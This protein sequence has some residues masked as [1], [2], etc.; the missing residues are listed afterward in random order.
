MIW[1]QR[2]AP[3]G[4]PGDVAYA[5]LLGVAGAAGGRL[6]GHEYADGMFYLE[7]ELPDG[8]V[9]M[10]MDWSQEGAVRLLLDALEKPPL[11][12]MGGAS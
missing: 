10:C 4:P 12:L 5:L 1:E 7:L 3:D 8:R 11:A 2:A 9:V 6:W